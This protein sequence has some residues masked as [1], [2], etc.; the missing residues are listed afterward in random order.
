MAR[1]GTVGY[2]NARP[3]S[4]R[5]DIDR[6]TLVM[7]H[8]AEVARM[9]RD[10]EVDVALVPVAAALS[11]GTFRIVPRVAIGSEGPVDSVLLVA[12]TPPEE[13][14]CVRLDGVSRTSAV[15]AQLLL[16]GPLAERVRPDLR[17]E[18]VGPNEGVAGAGGDV[19]AL[20]IGD[21]ARE[22]D[23]RWSVRIDLAELWNTWTGLPFVFAVWAGSPELDPVVVEHLSSCGVAGV[24][25]VPHTYAGRD[26]VYL[27]ERLRYDLDDKALMGLRR[28]AA[29]AHEAGLVGS[30]RV[31]LFGPPRDAH[32]RL[33]VDSLLAKALGGSRLTP[34][35][36]ELLYE[37]APL[38]D[39]AATAH[40]LRTMRHPGTSVS[41]ATCAP[42]A[43]ADP[44]GVHPVV[45]GV[46]DPVVEQLLGLRERQDEK[47]DVSGVRVW[48]VNAPGSYGSAANTA[49]DHQR[50]V[51]MARLVLDNVEHCDASP[52]TEGL[53][54]A[55][56]SLRMG[57][58][59]FGTVVLSGEG[60]DRE[61]QSVERHIQEAGF[62]PV[63][64]DEVSAPALGRAAEPSPPPPGG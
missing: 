19:A 15:L 45:V 38:A 27:S 20:V 3:L 9:L 16:A 59:R 26:L 10:G 48:A 30:E 56:A 52:S 46:G 21:A 14:R 6:H 4:D 57:C 41:Y 8:P 34:T 1:I 29:L 12:E 2:L 50:A 47:G 25:A 22:L 36:V 35:E 39:L 62:T 53:G 24:Q 43:F 60:S 58:D 44:P 61:V 17:I 51:A 18:P 54:M 5:I 31:E 63:R 42:D 64:L 23:E 13:W 7:A 33:P 32:P 11:D 49:S 28:F 40:E 55:Q 37:H